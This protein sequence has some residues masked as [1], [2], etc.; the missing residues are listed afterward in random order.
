MFGFAGQRVVVAAVQRR[1]KRLFPAAQ[2][3]RSLPGDVYK[4]E[5]T[6][7]MV[8]LFWGERGGEDELRRIAELLAAVA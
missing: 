3:L 2:R 6:P 5:A 7:Q 8:S 4:V 1:E